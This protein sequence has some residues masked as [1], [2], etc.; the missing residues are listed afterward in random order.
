MDERIK[1]LSNYR[2]EKAMTDLEASEILMKDGRFA[3]SVNRSYYAM[4]HAVRAL[5]AFERYDSK[6]HSGV[7]SFQ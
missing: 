4:F 2:L 5:M 3:Q 6:T 7:L 1:E